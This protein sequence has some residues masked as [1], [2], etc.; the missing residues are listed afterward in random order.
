MTINFEALLIRD[1]FIDYEFEEVTYRW[2]HLGKKIYVKFYGAQERAKPVAPDHRLYREALC[3]GR[4][5][6]RE[7]YEQGLP[8][9]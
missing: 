8:R 3:S 5:I 6:T 2:D 4:E 7:Q 9:R 1:V